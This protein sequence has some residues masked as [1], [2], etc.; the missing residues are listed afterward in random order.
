[1]TTA[2]ITHPAFLDHDTGELHP[3]RPDRMRA[4]NEAL[5]EESFVLLDRREAPLREDDKT[6]IAMAHTPAHVAALTAT[7]AHIDEGRKYIDGDTVASPGTW[8]AARR[9]VG[10]A[11]DAVDIVM[12]GEAANVFCQVRP[13]GHHAE[14]QQAM[15]FCFFNNVAIAAH[16]ARKKYGA[17]RVAVVDFDVHHGN[18]TQEIF[19]SDKD[20]F[21]GS[22]HQMPLF[23]GTGALR[24]TGVG[25]IF[26]A[27]L[28]AG[29]G[30]EQFE[31]AFRS[32]ILGP[33]HNF[34]PDVLLISAG[35]DAH[36]RDPLASLNLVAKDFHWATES[37][38]EVARRHSNGRIVS[39]LEGGYDLT[40]L[41]QSV[42]AHVKALIEAGH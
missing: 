14:S 3:E 32:R 2:L 1:M 31:E 19:W 30:R 37:L 7:V 26:N 10:A 29:D 27:P 16:Y 5:S 9:A 35:F 34:A 13:P 4:I 17:E 21:Y 24:E 28:R 38:S 25:N 6:Y 18:G 23:P 11:L 20:L 42:A 22:T 39:V 33:L 15:G 8:E 12:T 41:A 36:Q 40:G